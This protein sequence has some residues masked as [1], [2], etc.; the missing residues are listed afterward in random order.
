MAKAGEISVS[1]AFALH[2]SQP[3]ST[4]D[5]GKATAMVHDKKRSGDP[6]FDDKVP[7]D[8]QVGEQVTGPDGQPVTITESAG[9][10]NADG[11]HAVLDADPDE[12]D[13]RPA[14]GGVAKESST[15]QRVEPVKQAG[16]KAKPARS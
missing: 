1:S 14:E 16:A 3:G 8:E 12:G 2:G 7:M 15:V 5:S 6:D 4:H 9:P 10:V 13:N 11:T